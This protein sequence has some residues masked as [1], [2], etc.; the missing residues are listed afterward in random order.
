M[1][2]AGESHSMS[3][4]PYTTRDATEVYNVW[5]A[6][7]RDWP[8]SIADLHKAFA[9]SDTLVIE[10]SSRIIGFVA[11]QRG[12]GVNGTLS[13]LAVDPTAQRR[14]V[15]SALHAAAFEQMRQAGVQRV[16][17]G[18]GGPFRFWPGV[19]TNLPDAWEF[20]RA[21]S[22]TTNET[23]YDLVCD[24]RCYSTPPFVYE[25][26]HRDIK[27]FT[28]TA[29]DIDEV[30]AFEAREFP[31]WLSYFRQTASCGNLGDIVFARRGEQVVGSAL[32]FSA[33]SY[34]ST[35]DCIWRGLLGANMG[36]FGAI[37]VGRSERNQGIGL[38]LVAKASE[39]LKARDVGYS[40]AGWTWLVD[41][42]G[43]L[44]YKPWRTY[45]MSWRM[46]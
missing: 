23:A 26:L 32:L 17:L 22:W 36:G 37:G 2:A 24:L 43:R 42:Y 40:L 13:V 33:Q 44:G 1:A 29:T 34:G 19:P 45:A 6:A 18:G 20:F 31:E 14:H 46:L 15:G 12:M 10:Q 8:L 35:S 41:W 16:Q 27:L 25:R 4:R 7:L 28:A 39:N 30:L 38:A 5:R 11:T 3:I 21:Q 9:L